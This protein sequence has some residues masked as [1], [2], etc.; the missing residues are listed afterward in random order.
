M[1]PS[2]Q[3]WSPLALPPARPPSS[4][5]ALAPASSCAAPS[6]ASS[7]SS[8]LLQRGPSAA[9]IRL[10]PLPL[11]SRYVRKEKKDQMQEVHGW[12]GARRISATS[13]FAPS[14]PI[15]L[16][17]L[18]RTSGSLTEGRPWQRHRAQRRATACATAAAAGLQDSTERVDSMVEEGEGEDLRGEVDDLFFPR[19]TTLTKHENRFG[20]SLLTKHEI[21]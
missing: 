10:L 20:L 3:S 18:P 21:G 4:P 17:S 11:P 1:R 6:L 19:K 9:P 7:P 13:R 14:S 5:P 15:L 2:I 12:P 8:G 16:P